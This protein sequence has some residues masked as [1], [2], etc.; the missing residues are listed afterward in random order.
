M[1]GSINIRHQKH[2][3]SHSSDRVLL[4]GVTSE[5]HQSDITKNIVSHYEKVILE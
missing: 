4:P 3:N 5:Q 2:R 1:R